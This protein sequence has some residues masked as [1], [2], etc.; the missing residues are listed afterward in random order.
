MSD[1]IYPTICSSFGAPRNSLPCHVF[2]DG[3]DCPWCRRPR[4]RWWWL[5]Q[6]LSHLL[7]LA[8]AWLVFAA[9]VAAI[10]TSVVFVGV[11]V[12]VLPVFAAA[13]ATTVASVVL[14]GVGSCSGSCG[15]RRRWQLQLQLLSSAAAVVW[16]VVDGWW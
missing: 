11:G 9:A 13:P 12:G 2:V 10:V 1:F 16:C 8:L 3:Y 6:V 7:A 15:C 5:H 4:P 14:V